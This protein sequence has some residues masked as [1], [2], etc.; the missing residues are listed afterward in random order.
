LCTKRKSRARPLTGNLLPPTPKVSAGGVTNLSLGGEPEGEAQRQRATRRAEL[1][2]AAAEEGL[3]SYVCHE[4]N[5]KL[6]RDCA[7]RGSAGYAHVECL[8]QVLQYLPYLPTA[9]PR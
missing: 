6:L 7:C 9:V 2:A 3:M 4:N 1:E 8:V 5:G